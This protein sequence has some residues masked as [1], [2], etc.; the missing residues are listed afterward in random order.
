M[1]RGER[2]PEEKGRMEEGREERVDH[3]LHLATRKEC[4][5]LSCTCAQIKQDAHACA[6]KHAPRDPRFSSPSAF[7]TWNL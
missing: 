5:K 2:G 6:E 4:S 7:S 1:V 3:I